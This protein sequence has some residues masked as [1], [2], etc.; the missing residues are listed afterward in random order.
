MFRPLS[1]LGRAGGH[2]GTRDQADHLLYHVWPVCGQSCSRATGEVG[3]RLAAGEVK[4]VCR[5]CP[6]N[7]LWAQSHRDQRGGRKPASPRRFYGRAEMSQNS[8]ELLAARPGEGELGTAVWSGPGA[9]CRSSFK[10]T[11]EGPVER[12]AQ[13]AQIT[14][15]R[16]MVRL[17]GNLR[18]PQE[19]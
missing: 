18:F 1:G 17:P 10:A 8:E 9:F 7:Y 12:Q 13:L 16:L 5:P 11:A 19:A 2:G 6:S 14:E 4:R 15:E 3:W